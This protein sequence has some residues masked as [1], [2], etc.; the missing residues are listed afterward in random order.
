[1]ANTLAGRGTGGPSSS[2]R[3]GAFA[4]PTRSPRAQSASAAHSRRAAVGS[5]LNRPLERSATSIT[6]SPTTTA[7]RPCTFAKRMLMDAS[8]TEAPVLIP[9]ATCRATG[10]RYSVAVSRSASPRSGY[11]A[12]DPGCSD[13]GG[14]DAAG[15]A[16]LHGGNG[17]R[18]DRR[19]HPLRPRPPGRRPATLRVLLPG[20]PPLGLAG[21]PRPRP[22][23]VRAG[24]SRGRL[25]LSR[26]PRPPRS[27]RRRR[28][29]RVP[30]LPVRGWR[31]PAAH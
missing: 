26:Q 13:E 8:I 5:L 3:R 23:R 2:G 28:R 30:L 20:A 27:H 9:P 25:L 15:D 12:H 24:F 14:H 19:R 6:P 18:R 7:E 1:M 31:D 4:S 21:R 11:R 29:G 22:R 16:P 10:P 17:E